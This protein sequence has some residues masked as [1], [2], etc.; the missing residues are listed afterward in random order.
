MWM[1]GFHCID[2]VQ[3]QLIC[4]K[5]KKI[6]KSEKTTKM[7]LYYK[8]KL[9]AFFYVPFHVVKKFEE[10]IIL[11][12]SSK[13]LINSF[14]IFC[15]LVQNSIQHE[16]YRGGNSSFNIFISFSYFLKIHLCINYSNYLKWNLVFCAYSVYQRLLVIS[17]KNVI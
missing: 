10:K 1:Y 14:S 2:L 4:R 6:Q 12:K 7:S 11:L 15:Q 3:N 8:E 9:I 5:I 16:I 17:E 13:F